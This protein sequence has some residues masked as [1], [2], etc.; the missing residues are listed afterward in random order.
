MGAGYGTECVCDCG[1]GGESVC[2]CGRTC[3]VEVLK[4]N[5]GCIAGKRQARAKDEE[6]GWI[7]VRKVFYSLKYFTVDS[8]QIVALSLRYV[9]RDNETSM[10]R[11]PR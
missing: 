1:M 6:I 7:I 9:I 2:G 5:G 11:D 10:S 8:N 3:G 4:R